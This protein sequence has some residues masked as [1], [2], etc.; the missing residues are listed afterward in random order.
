M[1]GIWTHSEVSGICENFTFLGA[2]YCVLFQTG[3][4]KDKND[5]GAPFILNGVS[6]ILQTSEFTGRCQGID[7]VIL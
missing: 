2:S 6:L 3:M 5:L 7:F 1:E 4:S